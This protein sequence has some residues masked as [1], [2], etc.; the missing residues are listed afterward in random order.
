MTALCEPCGGNGWLRVQIDG[1]PERPAIQRCDNCSPLHSDEWARRRAMLSIEPTAIAEFESHQGKLLRCTYIC[2]YTAE[3]DSDDAQCDVI[4][5]VDRTPNDS[6]LH[7]NWPFLD[8]YWDVTVV[9]YITKPGP[10][11][12]ASSALEFRGTWIDGPSH[13]ILTGE[14]TWNGVQP[15]SLWEY[16]KLRA[17]GVFNARR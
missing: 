13:N 11:A 7:W 2:G 3:N 5:R 1:N 16:F 14:R 12:F 9:H 15:I 17:K 6:V 8:P 10:P 4:V